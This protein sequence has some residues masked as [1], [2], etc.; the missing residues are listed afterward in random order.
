MLAETVFNKEALTGLQFI[1][2]EQTGWK[3]YGNAA[4]M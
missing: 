2:G 1:S 4:G 3:S